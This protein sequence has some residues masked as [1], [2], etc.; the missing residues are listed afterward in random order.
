MQPAHVFDGTGGVLKLCNFLHS[1]TRRPSEFGQV[2][3]KWQHSW[4]YCHW[5]NVKGIF[6]SLDAKNKQLPSHNRLLIS[7]AVRAL[8]FFLMLSRYWLFPF[9][10]LIGWNKFAVMIWQLFFFFFWE[11]TKCMPAPMSNAP[12]KWVRNCY[13]PFASILNMTQVWAL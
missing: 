2:F 11:E 10:D 1:T 12:F 9:L 8:I 4:Y 3:G 6:K 13:V 7:V 5:D